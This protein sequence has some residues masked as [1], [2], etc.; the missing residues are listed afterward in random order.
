M[1]RKSFGVG[2]FLVEVDVVEIPAQ[3]NLSNRVEKTIL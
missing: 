1:R 3:V 2:R